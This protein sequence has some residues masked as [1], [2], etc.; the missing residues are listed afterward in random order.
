MSEEERAA[1]D[2]ENKQL[3][4]D[5]TAIMNSMDLQQK[6]IIIRD[7]AQM[8]PS[9]RLAFMKKLVEGGADA[10]VPPSKEEIAEWKGVY[11]SYF[12]S[13]FSSAKGRVMPLKYCVPNPRPDEI[14]GALTKHKIRN[15]FEAVSK[16]NT[17]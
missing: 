14:T 16:F 1:E 8:M 9:G 12:D 17:T 6:Q 13:R 3:Q 2:A 7:M 10:V 15:I 4:E 5:F 11:L